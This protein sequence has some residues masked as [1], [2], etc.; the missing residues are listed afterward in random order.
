MNEYGALRWLP[1]G[2]TAEAAVPRGLTRNAG[3]PPA[4][5]AR[6]MRALRV[7]G[8]RPAVAPFRLSHSPTHSPPINKDMARPKWEGQLC[9]ALR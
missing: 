8:P 1:V 7:V 9:R 2:R 6:K 4:W 3:V 5:Q